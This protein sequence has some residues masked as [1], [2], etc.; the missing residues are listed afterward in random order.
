MIAAYGA[1]ANGGKLIK[2]HLVKEIVDSEGNVVEKLKLAKPFWMTGW[3]E[4]QV[5]RKLMLKECM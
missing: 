3:L 2:P 4:R 1:I 5:L